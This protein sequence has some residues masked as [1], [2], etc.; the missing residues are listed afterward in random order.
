MKTTFILGA[1]A[2]ALAFLALS[3]PAS[4]ETVLRMNHQFPASAFGSGFDAWFAEEVERTTQGRVRIEIFWAGS[5]GGPKEN[6][7][8][9]SSGAIDMAAMS[10]GYF[11]AE[12]PLH[13]APNSLPMAMDNVRQAREIMLALTREIPAY[14]AE[15]ERLGIKSLFFHV[16]NPYYLFSTE[17]VEGFDDLEGM[18]VRTW[19]EDMPRLVEAAGAVPVTVFLPE[20]YESL[21]RGVVDACPFSLD[22]AVTYAIHEPAPHVTRVVMWEGP[23]WG[24][25]VNRESWQ[26]IEPADR[27]RIEAAAREAGERELAAARAAEEEA[28]LILQE[29]GVAFHDFPAEDLRRW[30]EQSPN[31]FEL[32]IGRMEKRGLGE[33]AREAVEL[34]REKRRELN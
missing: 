21:R 18:R 7:E 9:L 26:G 27:E 17:P 23:S 11:P 22:L 8:L 4:A 33:A 14:R 10:A 34:W 5:L 32:W 24:V 1:A 20:L 28:R 12:L 29:Q 19:G 16:L 6:L 13:A 15:A 25:W 2:C 3:V 31:F 30:K